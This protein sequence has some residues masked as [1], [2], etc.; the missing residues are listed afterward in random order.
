MSRPK[1]RQ[2]LY[3]GKSGQM[4]VMAE[5]LIRGYN[6]AVPE[7]DVGEDIFVVKDKEGELSRIQVKTA[8]AKELKN[9][10]FSATF[11]LQL[12]QLETPHTPEMNYV[13]VVRW[14]ARWA[15]FI[16]I[17]RREMYDL[18]LTRGVGSV[19]GGQV[20]FALSFSNEDVRCKGNSLHAYRNCWSRWPPIDHAEP[21]PDESED[22]AEDDAEVVAA[23]QGGSQ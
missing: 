10:G 3:T 7:V 17:G 15:E 21:A 20:V 11:N 19:Q 12:E 6:V 2:S 23:T 8:T 22:A 16:V 4:A 5:F 1:S 18:H 13:L 14:Q 9:G